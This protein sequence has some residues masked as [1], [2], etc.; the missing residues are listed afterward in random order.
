MTINLL[1][2]VEQDPRI[3][4]LPAILGGEKVRTKPEPKWPIY[5]D[6]DITAVT[7]V[8]KDV[9]GGIGGKYKPEFEQRFAEM[10][11]CKYGIAVCNGT[12]SLEISLRAMGIGAGDEVIVTPYTFIASA[13]AILMV[14]AI[15]I[16]VDIDEDTLN[17]DPEEIERAITNKTK[18]IVVVHIG[19][20]PADM[21]A[22]MNIADRHRL[23]VLEDCAHAH[24]SEWKGKRVGSFGHMGSFSFQNSKNLTSGEGGI[25]ITND[26]KLADRAWSIHNCG[27]V[28]GGAWYEHRVL[29]GN[30]RMT[31]FQAALLLSQMKRLPEQHAK[32]QENAAYLNEL[33]SQIPGIKP[34]KRDPRVTSNAQ[35]LYIF[36]YD[37]SAFAGLTRDKFI[38]AL[39]AEGIPCASG[40]VP[41]YREELF[42]TNPNGCPMACSFYG[43][44]AINYS[45]IKLPVV[46]R[47]CDSEAVWLFHSILLEER[48]DM[49]DI[50][51]AIM[52]ILRHARELASG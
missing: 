3:N 22:I 49:K 44:P 15:P 13:S 29:G 23:Y 8:V 16:F 30:Y 7:D 4:E 12:V 2:E 14:N 5:D 28:R 39:Q 10:H 11:N 9:W 27:R 1:A 42:V 48:Q 21:D 32:R 46:E 40:Y 20:C 34:Q 31:E 38:N 43:R 51:V 37:S 47:I 18:A 41:L 26:E 24:L 19:G 45:Q 33:L 35:H 52:K 36:R 25:I 50:A 17:I 6:T